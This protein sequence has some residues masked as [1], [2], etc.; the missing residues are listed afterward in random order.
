MNEAIVDRISNLE[1]KIWCW[2]IIYY[3]LG[4]SI[5]TDKMYDQT[6]KELQR[7]VKEYPEEFKASKHYKVFE[8]FSWVSG[9][10]LPLYDLDMTATAEYILYVSKHGYEA[11]KDKVGREPIKK[12]RTTKRN[13]KGAKK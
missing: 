9:Y 11:Y 2:A 10:D 5:V 8:H 12:K 1:S 6:S 4:D 7:L 13:R 3:R